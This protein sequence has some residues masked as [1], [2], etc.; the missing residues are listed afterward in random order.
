MQL[1]I[2]KIAASSAEGEKLF[3]DGES[4]LM[5][6]CFCGNDFTF[7]GKAKLSGTVTNKAGAFFL[8]MKVC[9]VSE[10]PCARCGNPVR[11]GFDFNLNEKLIKSGGAADDDAV[12][13]DGFS[14]NLDEFA[15]NGFLMNSSAKYLCSEEC[16]GL[17]PVCGKNLN[18]GDC[19]CGKEQSDPR[20]DILDNFKF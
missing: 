15:V 7:P 19:L 6:V 8:E 3:F 11:K 13:I 18:E 9:G 12:V 2:S 4:E 1:D 20:F 10:T 14:L 5:P 16:K 17:C